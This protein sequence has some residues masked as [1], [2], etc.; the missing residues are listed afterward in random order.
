M[1]LFDADQ[2]ADALAGMP[3]PARPWQLGEWA[4]L[5]CASGELC[6]GLRHVPDKEYA[7]SRQLSDT[8]AAIE[9]RAVAVFRPLMR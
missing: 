3:Y 1:A 9:Q 8:L 4:D 7:N 6:E 5:N 2:L